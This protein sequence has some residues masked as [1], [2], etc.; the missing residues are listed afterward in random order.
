[1]IIFMVRGKGDR[2][3]ASFSNKLFW[4]SG[5][6]SAHIDANLSEYLEIPVT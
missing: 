1:M 5:L 4:T 2:K 3:K 6:N